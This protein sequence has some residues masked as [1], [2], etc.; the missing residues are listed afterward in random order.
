MRRRVVVTGV[1][2]VNPL[3]NDVETMWSALKESRSGVDYTT[4]FDAKKFPTKIA[5]EIKNWD[6]SQ[7]GEDP[8]EWKFRG[9][10]TRFACGAAKQAV[11]DSGLLD[12]GIDP[13]RLGV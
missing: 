10:H 8:E 2:C 6:M 9:R 5:A 4:N 7:V 3:G 13:T 1:G 11:A 12:S